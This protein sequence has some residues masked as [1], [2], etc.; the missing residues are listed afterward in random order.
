MGN[1]TRVLSVGWSWE[2][3]GRIEPEAVQNDRELSR[4]TRFRWPQRLPS[5]SEWEALTAWLERGA[6]RERLLRLLP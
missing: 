1:G 4:L 3:A 6:G 2:A 5:D